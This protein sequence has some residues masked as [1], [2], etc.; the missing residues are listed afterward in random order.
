MVLF[1]E[2]VI[3]YNTGKAFIIRKGQR[4]CIAAESIV[5]YIAFNA[6]NL[7]ERFDQATTKGY[8]G[9]I[10]IS[11]GNSIYSNYHNPMMTILKDTYKGH[12]DLQYTMCSKRFYDKH[13]ELFKAGDQAI[14]ETFGGWIKVDKR[15]DL[16][17]HGC[18]ENFIEALDGYNIDPEYIPNP[19]D[20]FQ[21]SKVIGPSGKLMA[22]SKD[23]PSRA[24]KPF[25]IEMRAE[26][27]CLV[28]LSACPNFYA[29]ESLGKSITVQIFDK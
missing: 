16:P 5:D 6:D 20:M 19:F 28:A 24:G 25:Q 4:I 21:N 12:H 3:Q 11:S 22:A 27:N 26:I 18:L 14:V 23:I 15:E 1:G 9:R 2:I 17:D 8:N 10:F 29:K 7:K 13:Y